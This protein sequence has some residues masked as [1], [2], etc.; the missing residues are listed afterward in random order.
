ME[1]FV[2]IVQEKAV[3]KRNTLRYKCNNAM[4]AAILGSENNIEATL[5]LK[6]LFSDLGLKEIKEIVEQV[7]DGK[8]FMDAMNNI[9]K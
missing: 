4:T 9:N 3:E 5:F 8:T 2:K 7:R 1:D 6:T